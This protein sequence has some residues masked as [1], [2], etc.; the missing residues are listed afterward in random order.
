MCVWVLSSP[1]TSNY[2]CCWGCS[3]K[4]TLHYITKL[5]YTLQ[6]YIINGQVVISSRIIFFVAPLL[7]NF[8]IFTYQCVRIDRLFR[9]LYKH[10]CCVSCLFSY[11]WIH[12]SLFLHEN[13]FQDE[14]ELIRNLSSAIGG[15]EIVMVAEEYLNPGRV[16][17][18]ATL[19]TPVETPL[20]STP[21]QKFFPPNMPP[22]P[23]SSHATFGGHT[24]GGASHRNSRYDYFNT[25]ICEF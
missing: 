11:L 6:L 12:L 7:F 4:F 10:F 23:Y 15:N 16:T 5:T 19:N 9:L 25:I 21:T 20:P 3:L 24:N 13:K 18:T 14:R 8:V 17:S 2:L 22:P 1:L